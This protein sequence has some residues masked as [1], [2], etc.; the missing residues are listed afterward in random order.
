MNSLL[1]GVIGTVYGEVK[2]GQPKPVR[3][4]GQPNMVASDSS[5]FKHQCYRCSCKMKPRKSS[6]FTLVEAKEELIIQQFKEDL[7]E[8][9]TFC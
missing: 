8:T 2:T 4:V 5:Y 9:S 7:W 6:A 1:W 3:T